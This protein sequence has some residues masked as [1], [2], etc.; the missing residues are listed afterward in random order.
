VI[1]LRTGVPLVYVER[2]G[3]I[4]SVHTG[5]LVVTGP[6]GSVRHSF[7]YPAQPVFARSCVKPLQAAGMLTA[8]LIATPQEVAL[9]A[10]SHS[11][12]PRHLAL[13]EAELAAAGLSATDLRCPPALPL[14]DVECRA[15][16]ASGATESRVA[17]NC[18]GKHAAMLR[19]CMANGWPITDYLAANHPLQQH[20]AATVA[21]LA[22]EQLA[23]T[24]VD[25][26]GAPL[27]A[28]SL[29]GLARAFSR[30]ALSP[31]VDA[32]PGAF[33]DATATVAE[34]MRR[35][36]GLVGG[37]NRLNTRLMTALPGLIAKD[38]AEG[39]FA[40]ALADG[41]AVAVKIDDGAGR[42]A[43]CA[44]L[45]GLGLLGCDAETL[46]DCGPVAVLG[47]GTVVGAVRSAL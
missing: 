34:A 13:I 3:V 10:A 38:G 25:G 42:A 29:L 41:G 33:S 36:P 7:G 16:L 20:L 14:G 43:E 22:S 11:G 44:V 27:F 46:A 28:F 4:E 5:H 35:H 26:C 45:H 6:D 8:G 37:S 17:M 39:C 15:Y 23:A 19:T 1:T 31:A 18:S 2:S 47:G 24:G 32:G 30:L 40:L 9:A 21:G 12:S